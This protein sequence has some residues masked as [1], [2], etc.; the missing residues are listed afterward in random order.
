MLDWAG[1]FL[2]FVIMTTLEDF[3]VL[4]SEYLY[5]HAGNDLLIIK[6]NNEYHLYPNLSKL[7]KRV[8]TLIFMYPIALIF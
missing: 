5:I 3:P 7:R 4:L 8:Y 1:F 2:C 6:L